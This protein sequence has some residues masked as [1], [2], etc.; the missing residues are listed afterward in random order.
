VLEIVRDIHS[1]GYNLLQ[2]GR[3][4][5]EHLRALLLFKLNP[6]VLEVTDEEKGILNSSS[7]FFTP[8]CSSGRGILLT[9]AHDE[10]R[11]SEQP[12]SSLAFLL[13]L[14]QPYVDAND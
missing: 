12:G 9:K 14:V 1:Q 13:K 8:A 10:M 4:L 7:R 6:S 3:D 11:W 2:F 5:R